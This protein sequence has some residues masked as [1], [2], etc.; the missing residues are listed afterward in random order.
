MSNNET[1]YQVEIRCNR[2]VILTVAC[3]LGLLYPVHAAQP[4]SQTARTRTELLNELN[5]R[6]AQVSL[7]RAGEEAERRQNEYQDSLRLFELSIISKA[8]LDQALSLLTKSNQTLEQAKIQLEQTKLGFL[9][10]ATHITVMEA[11]KYY[12]DQGR[13]MLDLFLKNTSN[14]A[15]A[16]VALANVSRNSEASKQWQ[17]VQSIKALLNIENI[18]VSIVDDSASIAKPYEQII[19]VL[20]YD[21]QVKCSFVLLT[22]VQ[23]AGVRLQYLD[24]N[25]TENIYL[26]KESLQNKPTL[27]ASQFS[28]EGQL[29]S[30]VHYALDLEMLVTSDRS[31]ALVVTNMPP[32]LNSCFKASSSR[33][34]S[35][36]FSEQVSRHDVALEIS[37]PQKLDVNRIDKKIEFQVWAVTAKQL[38]T[39]N[40]LKGQSGGEGIPRDAFDNID[41][42][43]LDLTIIPKG[44]GR[45]EILI[46]NLYF[47]K[48][49]HETVDLTADIHNDGTLTLFDIVPEIAPPLGWDIQVEPGHINRLL[50][51]EERT[52][53]IQLQPS[54]DVGVGEYE[55]QIGARGQS[56]SDAIEAI[57]KRL[58]IR[59]HAHTS[60]ATSLSL[61]GGLVILI[62]AIVAFGV[63]LSRR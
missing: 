49:P 20:Q 48:Y 27:T 56:G 4:D 63:R 10:N 17:T 22:D 37:I 8:E 16:E 32:Q 26:E 41:A 42:A 51:D 50:P 36:R 53:R 45:L 7:D 60:V 13:R 5:L 21:E 43:R 15:Q 55:T 54:M 30:D 52:I 39:L 35:V 58:R 14:L 40:T 33:I 38:D 24:K 6:K 46:N 34:T 1:H 47:E 59:V 9:D 2:N 12:D 44:T 25:I 19:P 29:G 61:I 18:I 31:F 23:R 11:K 28:L 57:D 3:L 62:T